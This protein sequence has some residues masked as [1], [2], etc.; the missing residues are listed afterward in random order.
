MDNVSGSGFE[1][2][3]AV[4]SGSYASAVATS[5]GLNAYQLETRCHA[6]TVVNRPGQAGF[7]TGYAEWYGRDLDQLPP[8]SVA[9]QAVGISARNENPRTVEPGQYTVILTPNAVGLLLYYLSW[10]GLHAR[11]VQSRQ[12]FLTGRFGEQVLDQKISI[13][14]DAL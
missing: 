8:E 10:M 7:G 4:S 11:S 12:S 14:D 2:A 9:Q 3:G 1:A 5:R 13:R 6:L